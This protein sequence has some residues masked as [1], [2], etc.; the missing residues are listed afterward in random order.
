MSGKALFK[1][2]PS[3]FAVDDDNAADFDTYEER[4]DEM[5]TVVEN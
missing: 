4:N 3:L 5:E 2:D 1:Y